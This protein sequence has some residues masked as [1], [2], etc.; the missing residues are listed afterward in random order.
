MSVQEYSLKFTQLSRYATEIVLDMRNMMSLFVSGLSCLSSKKGRTTPRGGTLRTGGGVNR[1]YAITSL[2]D[3]ENSPDVVSMFNV[4]TFDVYALIYPGASLS[5][6]TPIVAMRFD[7]FL[8]QLLKLLTVST[9]GFDCRTRVVKFQYPNEQVLKWR[10]SSAVL[11][12]HFISYLK[13]IKLVS[14][15]CIYHLVLVDDS[16]VET[17]L[18]RLVPVVSEFLEVFTNDFPGVSIEK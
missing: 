4:F 17:L 8:D 5:F 3:L 2:Q 6:V 14:K 9:P 11:K 12:G 7:I 1:E 10:S 13:V 18:I 16:S 15:G